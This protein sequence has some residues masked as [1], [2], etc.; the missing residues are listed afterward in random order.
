MLC[1]FCVSYLKLCCVSHL[2]LFLCFSPCVDFVFHSLCRVVLI[3]CFS[4]F[5]GS[6]SSWLPSWSPSTPRNRRKP[7]N[8]VF[9]WWSS[10]CIWWSIYCSM[11]IHHTFKCFACNRSF[12]KYIQMPKQLT[13]LRAHRQMA[14]FYDDESSLMIMIIKM[15]MINIII[16]TMAIIAMVEWLPTDRATFILLAKVGAWKF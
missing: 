12:W 6:V 4:P 15:K 9:I 14:M 5:K 1:W 11:L 16:M 7:E 10:N 2:R 8:I 13:W 3:L